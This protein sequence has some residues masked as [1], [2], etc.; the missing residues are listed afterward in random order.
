MV[1]KNVIIMSALHRDAEVSTWED[2]KPA[3]IIEENAYKGGV[4]NLDKVT[5]TYSS[6]RITTPWP[7]AIFYNIS[8]I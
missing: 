3:I 2:R 8:N 5:G 1:H 7:F 4:D 6:K